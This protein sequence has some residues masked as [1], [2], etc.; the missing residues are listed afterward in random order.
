METFNIS[1]YANVYI[2]ETLS[3]AESTNTCK[4]FS[5]ALAKRHG[6]NYKGDNIDKY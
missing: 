1:T 6:M 4:I 3:N 2:L 5:Y